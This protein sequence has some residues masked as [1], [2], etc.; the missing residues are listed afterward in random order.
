VPVVLLAGTAAVA[1]A[2]DVAGRAGVLVQPCANIVPTKTNP[3]TN[4]NTNSFFILF[5]L[6]YTFAVLFYGIY[7]ERNFPILMPDGGLAMG[8]FPIQILFFTGTNSI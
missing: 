5:S 6:S 2:V 8:I 4:A 1:E 3:M 7:R